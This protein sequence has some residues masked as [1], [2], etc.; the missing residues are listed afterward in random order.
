MSV[1]RAVS[2]S[3][4]GTG[5]VDMQRLT[6]KLG[7]LLRLAERATYRHFIDAVEITPVQYSLLALVADNEGLAQGVLGEALNLDGAT[8][9][10][11]MNRLEE[12]E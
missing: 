6:H 8:T 9:M 1:E 5:E 11:I 4:S 3:R 10:A 12:R 7:Y 2:E